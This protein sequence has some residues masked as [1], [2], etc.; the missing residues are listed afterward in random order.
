MATNEWQMEVSGIVRP[1]AELVESGVT[2]ATVATL[3]AKAA[4]EVAH[5]GPECLA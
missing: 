5:M 2:V 1:G 4:A 3:A